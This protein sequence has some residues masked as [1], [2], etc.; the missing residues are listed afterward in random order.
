[1]TELLFV[2]LG[3]VIGLLIAIL[4]SLF[5]FENNRR[6]IAD[7]VLRKTNAAQIVDLSDPYEGIEEKD[8]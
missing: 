6:K 3:I 4:L 5:I 8:E 7:L 2:L 1:M